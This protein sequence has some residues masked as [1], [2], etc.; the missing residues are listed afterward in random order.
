MQTQNTA[1][2]ISRT[3]FTPDNIVRPADVDIEPYSGNQC[4]ILP[5]IPSG[6][7]LTSVCGSPNNRE[8]PTPRAQE[9][10]NKSDPT[11]ASYQP[12]Q[13]VFKGDQGKRTSIFS[14]YMSNYYLEK[15]SETTEACDRKKGTF[16]EA[17]NAISSSLIKFKGKIGF[18]GSKNLANTPEWQSSSSHGTRQSEV[19][20]VDAFSKTID[21]DRR[22]ENITEM[23]TIVQNGPKIVKDGKKNGKDDK[24]QG[25]SSNSISKSNQNRRVTM[26]PPVKISY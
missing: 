12:E 18:P 5:K 22:E 11:T 25:G 15:G 24:N 26:V 23:D 17:K 13:P 10:L 3:N 20:N 19:S 2:I 8:N 21:D 16:R 6:V 4:V 9:A 1:S 14:D 7:I